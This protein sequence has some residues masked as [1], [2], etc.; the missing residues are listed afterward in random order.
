LN[1]LDIFIAL[2]ILVGAY[3]GYKNGFLMGLISLTAIILGVFGGFKLMGEGMIFLQR[4]FNADK[5]VLPYLSFLAIFIII[6]VLVNIIGRMIKASIDKS[7][8]GT[9]DAAMGAILGVV[10]WLFMLSVV[11]WLLDSLEMTPG[12]DWTEGSYLYHYTAMFA[13]ELSGWMS[14]FLPFFKETFKQF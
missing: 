6:V 7:F 10:K 11:L 2:L 8:L 13:T 14:G 9:V 1:K 3:S 4:E 12:P 5:S